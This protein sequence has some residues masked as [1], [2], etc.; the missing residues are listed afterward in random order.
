MVDVV[1]R[2]LLGVPAIL[3]FLI[4]NNRYGMIAIRG[5]D[6]FDLAIKQSRGELSV[7][8]T[9]KLQLRIVHIAKDSAPE[10]F[11]HLNFNPQ[12]QNQVAHPSIK[13]HLIRQILATT[14]KRASPLIWPRQPRL[15]EYSQD[16]VLTTGRSTVSCSGCK[17]STHSSP[18]TTPPLYHTKILQNL[19]FSPVLSACQSAPALGRASEKPCFVHHQR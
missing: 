9:R 13:S 14:D 2:G 4:D 6:K 12:A 11:T 18:G 7:K 5:K 17:A 19:L 15:C 1:R 3:S 8:A 10:H 16:Y